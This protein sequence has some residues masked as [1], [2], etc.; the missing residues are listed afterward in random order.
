MSIRNLDK[1][2]RP[3]SIAVIGASDK[4]RS[5][6]A[7]LMT[8]LLHAGF[9]GP[10]VPVNPEADSVHGINVCAIHGIERTCLVL[11]VLEFALLMGCGRITQ[12]RR[13]PS[14]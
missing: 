4:A 14:S 5:V 13:N 10:I 8:N 2:F 12:Y 6:G 3:Q 7:A 1:M 11:A 9:R